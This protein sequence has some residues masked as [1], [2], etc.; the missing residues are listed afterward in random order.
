MIRLAV[1]SILVVLGAPLAPAQ[2]DSV[3]IF[4]RL[5]VARL[6]SLARDTAIHRR[7]GAKDGLALFRTIKPDALG[8][9]DDAALLD[10]VALFNESLARADAATCA[11]I[12]SKGI[13]EGFV[14]LA[15]RMD[16]T[17]AVGW[18][19]FVER[20]L[21]ASVLDRPMGALAPSDE[22]HATIAAA[23][24]ALPAAD[25]ERRGRHLS[26]VASRNVRSRRG[27]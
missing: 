9:I 14:G 21:W 13:A 6:D 24:L 10:L 26:P 18:T 8:R 3:P 7:T 4:G 12:H 11:D 25:Q 27:L 23:V 16:S 22:V 5:L 20:M 17:L 1:V 2:A 19:T 15:T